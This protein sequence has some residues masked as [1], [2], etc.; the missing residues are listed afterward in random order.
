MVPTFNSGNPVCQELVANSGRSN[1]GESIFEKFVEKSQQKMYTCVKVS[2][3]DF[4]KEHSRLLSTAE[5]ALMSAVF[6]M[7]CSSEA[8]RAVMSEHLAQGCTI[9]QV[10]NP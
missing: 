6:A 2:A 4:A 3:V 9:Q 5:K 10:Q 8:D 1:R 7:Q